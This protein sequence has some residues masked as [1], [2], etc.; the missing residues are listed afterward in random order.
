MSKLFVL[1]K[2]HLNLQIDCPTITTLLNTSK[3]GADT[4]FHFGGGGGLGRLGSPFPLFPRINIHIF[5]NYK[6]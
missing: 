6:H 3:S 4:G 1:R 5:I 2:R